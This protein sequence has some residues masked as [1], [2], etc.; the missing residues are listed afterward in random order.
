MV[1]WGVWQ[2]RF[3]SGSRERKKKR[4]GDLLEG[5]YKLKG[6]SFKIDSEGQKEPE[7]EPGV[8]AG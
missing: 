2:S 5:E 4:G 6:S 1:E 3:R 7:T 8:M